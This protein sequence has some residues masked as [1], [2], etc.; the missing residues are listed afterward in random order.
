MNKPLTIIGSALGA[1]AVIL[2]AFGAHGL[3]QHLSASELQTFHTANRYHFFHVFAIFIVAILYDRSKNNTIKFAGYAFFAGIILF[4]GSL[5]LL[6][7]KSLLNI[8]GW[9]FLG[10]VTPVGGLLFILGWL[11]ILAGALKKGKH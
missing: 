2:G 7:T 3:S 9:T 4:S 1:L 10:P 5:Y 8:E 6:A 11:L